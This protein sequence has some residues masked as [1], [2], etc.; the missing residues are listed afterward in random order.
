MQ[1]RRAQLVNGLWFVLDAV[2]LVVVEVLD[3]IAKHFLLLLLPLQILVRLGVKALEILF[4]FWGVLLNLS[5]EYLNIHLSV[6]HVNADIRGEFTVGSDLADVD[7]GL[8]KE[9]CDFDVATGCRRMET[10]PA[11]VV[12]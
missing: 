9:L 10:V 5:L 11:L 1:W 8:N 3:R 4:H 6:A 2:V 12:F 7:A